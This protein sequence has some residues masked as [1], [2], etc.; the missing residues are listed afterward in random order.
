MAD[1]SIIYI[2]VVQCSGNRHPMRFG[3]CTMAG[4]PVSE[5]AAVVR[6]GESPGPTSS[7]AGL[8]A[9]MT[10][11]WTLYIVS[12]AF[13]PERAG[14]GSL[15]N[16]TGPLKNCVLSP[17]LSL[18]PLGPLPSH[19]LSCLKSSTF[20]GLRLGGPECAPCCR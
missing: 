10:S 1:V 6:L 14:L 9:Q 2:Y 11:T 5:A 16:L 18:F 20:L 12:Q 13:F 17:L 19:S 15:E 3:S 4:S 8:V 7:E